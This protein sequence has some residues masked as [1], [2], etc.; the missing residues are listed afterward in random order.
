[1]PSHYPQFRRSILRETNADGRQL[2]IPATTGSG[3]KPRRG[4]L[5]IAT[6]TH[7]LFFLFFGGAAFAMTMSAKMSA[8][9]HAP[10]MG[11]ATAPRRRKTKAGRTICVLPYKQATPTGFGMH[12]AKSEPYMSP[13][14]MWVMTRHLC[15]FTVRLSARVKLFGN[16]PAVRALK[17]HKCRAPSAVTGGSYDFAKCMVWPCRS[18]RLQRPDIFSART[19]GGP[20][21]VIRLV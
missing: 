19:K 18:C 3:L 2:P 7:R 12:A 9:Q 21:T 1:M 17:R 20:T 4:G 16:F 14:K 5:F 13:A 11:M 6:N 10:D 15:R 8:P